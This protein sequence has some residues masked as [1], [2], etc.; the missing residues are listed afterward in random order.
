MT[1]L[2][3][4]FKAALALLIITFPL[5][6]LPLLSAIYG[7]ISF[8][9]WHSNHVDETVKSLYLEI[10]HGLRFDRVSV[11]GTLT[12]REFQESKH[13][14]QT[15]KLNSDD[16]VSKLGFLMPQEY[17]DFG[18][19]DFGIDK[20]ANLETLMFDVTCAGSS[21]L[22]Q[23]VYVSSVTWPEVDDWDAAFVEL[24]QHTNILPNA[25]K[26]SLAFVKCAQSSFLCGVWGVE[27]PALVHFKVEPEALEPSELDPDLTYDAEAANLRPVT[28]RVVELPLSDAYIHVPWH[29]LP[30]PYLQLRSIVT[31]PA[32]V[33][34]FDTYDAVQQIMRRFNQYDDTLD[35]PGSLRN[36]FNRADKWMA[37]YVTEPLGVEPAIGVLHTATF[38]TSVVITHVLRWPF[39]TA[40]GLFRRWLGSPT[41]EEEIFGDGSAYEGSMWSD[42]FGGFM[43]DMVEKLADLPQQPTDSSLFTSP[44]SSPAPTS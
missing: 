37:R 27:A 14:F 33:E 8:T 19:F 13:A 9:F 26:P 38:M 22:E 1:I 16:W 24:V 32:L 20:L 18:S 42:I 35:R 17:G 23:W 40:M 34:Q 21:P 29:A 7:G 36:A 44:Y 31:N 3:S 25:T 43:N 6:L 15:K 2:R 4:S 28:V 11:P 39:T 12:F 5:T 30:S 10:D 41:V